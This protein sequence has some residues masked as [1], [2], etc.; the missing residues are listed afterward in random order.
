MNDIKQIQY[1]EN[2]RYERSYLAAK[3]LIN[4]SATL[5]GIKPAALLNFSKRRGKD[6]T[7]FLL[8]IPQKDILSYLQL[9][10]LECSYCGHWKVYGNCEKANR[11]F[12]S[13]RKTRRNVMDLIYSGEDPIKILQEGRHHY[14][15]IVNEA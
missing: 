8:G 7:S 15:D 5:Y 3:V 11:L 14:L 4:V 6:L 10:P 12:Q 13:Y 1:I 2:L 9:V